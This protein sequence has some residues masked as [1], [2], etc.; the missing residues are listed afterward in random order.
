MAMIEHKRTG[1][2]VQLAPRVMVGRSRQ[3][4]L[5]LDGTW[6]S[7]EHAVIGWDGRQWRV[8]DLGSRNGT[9]LDGRP[10]DA[11]TDRPLSAGSAL[12]FGQ[13][14][15]QWVVVD[16]GAPTPMAQG[17]DG[18]WVEAID[19]VLSLP[20]EGDP[21]V[22]VRHEDGRWVV[23]RQDEEGPP[24]V[25]DD[26]D[27]IVLGDAIWTL[28]LPEAREPTGDV[29]STHPLSALRLELG[30][31][32][33]EE[34]IDVRLMRGALRVGVEPRAHHYLLVLLVRQREADRGEA[35]SPEEQGWIDPD[36]LA[37]MLRISRQVLNVYIHRIRCQVSDAG[38]L[39]GKGIIER[40]AQSHAVR[41]ALI[42]AEVVPL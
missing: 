34:T 6:V 5:R 17:P 13:A 40:R 2:R 29:A 33:D 36:R 41:L 10:L 14:E 39:D 3:A 11:R 12:A 23:E 1:R 16:V 30:L 27:Q 19:R 21:Q 9:T 26:R 24:W 35:R 37:R 28:R 4:D 15:E 38:V 22:T 7:G 20:G 18:R 8:R 42:D 31:S 25:A 32:R